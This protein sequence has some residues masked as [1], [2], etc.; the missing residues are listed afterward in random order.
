MSQHTGIFRLSDVNE[1]TRVVRAK[2]LKRGPSPLGAHEAFLAAYARLSKL[3]RL[4]QRPAVLVA[5]VDSSARVVEVVLVASGHSLIIGRHTGCGLRLPSD[6]ISLRQLAVHVWSEDPDATPDLRLWD[7]N[8][9]QPFL[10]EDGEPNAAVIAQGTLYAAVGEYALLFVPTCGA[11]APSWPAR[12]EEAW[13]QLPPRHFVDQRTPT[14][15]RFQHSKRPLR[16]DG[17]EYHTRITRLGPLLM[18]GEDEQP[19]DAWAALRLEGKQKSEEHHISLARLEQGV[20]LGRYERCGITLADLDPISRVHLL[21]VR[22]G[23]DILAIDT[24]STNGTWRGHTKIQTTPL[25]DTDSLTLGEV[26]Q[27]RWRR[28]SRLALSKD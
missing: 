17:Q 23:A 13:R 25:G 20:L 10:T 19:E 1:Q 9:E 2:D 15:S 28:L 26:L 8:T 14:R 3:A 27:L 5:A 16:P 12:A 21:L 7:L 24:A 6:T 11:S 4:S 22:M 18:L